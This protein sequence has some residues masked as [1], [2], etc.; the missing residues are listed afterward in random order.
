MDDVEMVARKLCEEACAEFGDP[1]CWE[2]DPS[3]MVDANPECNCV[4][5]AHTAVAALAKD[6]L[7]A[8]PGSEK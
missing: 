8:L 1:P 6:R 2:V 5:I 7:S 4:A 3:W